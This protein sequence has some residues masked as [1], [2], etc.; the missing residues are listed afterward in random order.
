MTCL[1]TEVAAGIVVVAD[2][3]VVDDV[4][5]DDVDEVE[6]DEV[7]LDEVDVDIVLVVVE[8]PDTVST[9][10]YAALGMVPEGGYERILAHLNIA[11]PVPEL[12]GFDSPMYIP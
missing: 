4:E 2:I 5:I 1:T 10:L 8:P 3:V 11:D 7:V 12:P 9:A 6:I